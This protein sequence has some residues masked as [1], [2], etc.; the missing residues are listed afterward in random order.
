MFSYIMEASQQLH[1]YLLDEAPPSCWNKLC[2]CFS[3]RSNESEKEID[4]DVPSWGKQK[5]T[6]QSARKYNRREQL[7]AYN[8]HI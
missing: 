4:N 2:S 7:D 3:S 6:L 1:L 5:G 8:K